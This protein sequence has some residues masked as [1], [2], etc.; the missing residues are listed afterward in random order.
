MTI[1]KHSNIPC[2]L[3]I[4]IFRFTGGLVQR[5]GLAIFAAAALSTATWGADSGYLCR[6]PA[7]TIFSTTAGGSDEEPSP[8][9][10]DQAAELPLEDCEQKLQEQIRT[11]QPD[12][13]VVL[14]A[15]VVPGINL[16]RRIRAAG[17][18]LRSYGAN[19]PPVV[20]LTGGNPKEP[21]RIVSGIEAQCVA[22]QCL[23]EPDSDR[24]QAYRQGKSVSMS[25]AATL[26]RILASEFKFPIDKMILEGRATSTVGN[27]NLSV[28]LLA[29]RGL[30]KAVILT[31]TD[32]E[33]NHAAR[34][35]RNFETAKQQHQSAKLIQFWAVSWPYLGGPPA[36]LKG[37]P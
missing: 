13:L 34:A 9:E 25:E 19:Q 33:A 15:S 1:V 37:P 29:S 14:G 18:L 16:G 31:T 5:V 36:W 26:C 20:L 2:H 35:L 21:P 11:L 8:D 3:S 30:A 4:L 32:G 10:A 12:A 27:A 7:N 6:T 24:C 28:P 23:T 22:R 17:R